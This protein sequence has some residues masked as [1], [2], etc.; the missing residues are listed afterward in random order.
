[1]T[2]ARLTVLFGLTAAA[3]AFRA[4]ADEVNVWPVVVQQR[5]PSGQV[6]S[7]TGAGP[8]LFSTPSPAPEAGTNRGFRPFYVNMKT[9]ESEK[10]DILYPLFYYR[11]YPDAYKWSVFQ[12][13]NGEGIDEGA[14]RAGLPT[15]H[16]FD[17]WPFY[18]SHETGSPEDSYRALFPVYGT[19]K[20]RL[21]FDRLSWILFPLYVDAYKKHTD[22]TYTPFPFVRTFR[23]DENGFA[24]WPL[25]GSTTGPGQSRHFYLL[26]PFTWN[27]AVDAGPDAPEGTAPTTQVGVLPLFTREK[28]PGFVNE[29]FLW[30]FFGFTERTTPYRYSERRYLWPFLVQGRGDDRVLD[31]WGPFYTYSNIKGTDSRW[32]MWPLWHR[33]TWVDDDIGQAK[34]QFFYFLYWSLD[35][36]SVSRPSLAPAYK[37]HFWPVLSIWDNGAGSRQ[38]QFPSPLEVFFV[39]NPDIRQVWSPLFSIYRYDHRPTGEARGSVLWGALTWK[40]QDGQGL[41]E[42]HLGPLLG[43]RR[44]GPAA[45]WKIL[46]FDFG[47]KRGEN[48][49]AI[50]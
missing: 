5:D 19:M 21:G 48:G 1:M 25:F 17:I 40:R 39:S 16:H 38:V 45:P 41:V 31:R 50:R 20:Y 23:G 27:N 12:L 46:G 36:R 26:W 29:N 22:V 10:T 3:A 34:T 14:S 30:P 43:M 11:K 7:W 18:F 35:Q 8:L 37:R 24:L 47:A 4:Q 44:E 6:V 2:L 33:Q 32:I 13:I 49:S 42:F 15:D 28:S 9:D